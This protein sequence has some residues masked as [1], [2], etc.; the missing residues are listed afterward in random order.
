MSQFRKKEDPAPIVHI[1]R[2][3]TWSVPRYYMTQ[4][5]ESLGLEPLYPGVHEW[6]T[7]TNLE[8]GIKLVSDLILK[9]ALYKPS[10]FTCINYA[11]RVWNEAALRFGL[12][13]WIPVIGR[14]PDATVRHAWILILLGDETGFKMEWSRYFEPNDGYQMGEELEMAFQVFPIGEEGYSGELSFY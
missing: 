1:P 2:F 10:K 8:G 3:K 6:Y 4:I 12:N 9:S 11:F 5:V 13:T 7:Y 14:L